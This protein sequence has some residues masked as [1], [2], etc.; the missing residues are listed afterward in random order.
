MISVN[1]NQSEHT[2]EFIESTL[3]SGYQNL[4]III[5]DNASKKPISKSLEK[6]FDNLKIIHSKENLGFAG[7]NN[8]GLRHATGEYFFFLNNDTVVKEE[9]FDLMV[10]F[11]LDHPETGILSPKILFLNNHIQYAGSLKINALTGRG[12]KIGNN[13]LDDSKYDAIYETAYAHGAAMAVP[14]EVLSK[15][16]PMDESYFLYYEELDWT[17]RIKKAGYK[18]YYFGK[19]SILHKESMSIGK[20]SPLQT[21]YMNRNRI[22]FLIKNISP[23]KRIIALIFFFV[24][25]L[26]KSTCKYLIQRKISNLKNLWRGILWHVNKKYDFKA[27]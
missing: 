6:K 23:L 5:V 17:E 27:Y 26:P 2:H 3:N 9:F 24:I 14:K 25:S 18:A 4:E 16:G 7:G 11:F 15:V 22:L 21:Y 20:E 12:K 8:L 13:E 1:Y 10:K 19:T